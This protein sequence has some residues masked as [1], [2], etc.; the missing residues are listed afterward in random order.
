MV[1]TKKEQF[2]KS[3]YIHKDKVFEYLKSN[4]LTEEQLSVLYVNSVDVTDSDIPKELS[5]LVFSGL[6]KVEGLHE[7][8]QLTINKDLQRYFA[9]QTPI[10]QFNIKGACSRTIY[11]KSNLV[12]SKDT[13]S[14]KNSKDKLDTNIT[15]KRYQSY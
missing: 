2:N 9:A 8:L 1:K 5:E 3:D 6:S 13:K 14:S 4:P 15:K 11:L 10:E 12:K 7:Y